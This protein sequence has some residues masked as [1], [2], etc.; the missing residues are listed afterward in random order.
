[1]LAPAP[2]VHGSEA[3]VGA[4]PSAVCPCRHCCSWIL[5][6]CNCNAAV[7][8]VQRGDAARGTV[9]IQL[10]S[11]AVRITSG[12]I[13]P[14]C[15]EQGHVLEQDNA[16]EKKG[17]R[18]GVGEGGGQ[19]TCQGRGSAGHVRG[20]E[21]ER[22]R[23]RGE[24]KTQGAYTRR[25]YAR[26]KTSRD[27]QWYDRRRHTTRGILYNSIIYAPCTL[28]RHRLHKQKFILLKKDLRPLPNA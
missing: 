1:M 26:W 15:H 13:P 3:H 24:R 14:H 10:P 27:A 6:Q 22:G 20:M 21:R 2:A 11:I 9:G 23:G 8:L 16:W 7:S 18:R 4:V 25:I 28:G 17:M 19:G 12:G 5:M